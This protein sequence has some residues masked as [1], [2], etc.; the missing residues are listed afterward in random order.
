MVEYNCR[1]LR[2]ENLWRVDT[3]RYFMAFTRYDNIVFGIDIG[4]QRVQV[5]ELSVLEGAA[6]IESLSLLLWSA[7]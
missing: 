4:F 3:D 7:I 2:A 5:S 6:S 1:C